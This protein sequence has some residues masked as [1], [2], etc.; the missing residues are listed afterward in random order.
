MKKR[1][2]LWDK[3]RQEYIYTSA[4]IRSLASKYRCSK[5][6]VDRRSVAEGWVELRHKEMMDVG[7]EA[8]ARIREKA[9]ED[10]V[11]L[12]DATRAAVEKRVIAI[13]KF[14]NDAD[15]LFK[16]I[17]QYEHT[18]QNGSLKARETLKET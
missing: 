8:H 2:I 6:A 7:R 11:R 13:E 14:T 15:G 10:H 3:M 5:R 9:I 16:H 12:Y 1:V 18:Y 17:V 4:T